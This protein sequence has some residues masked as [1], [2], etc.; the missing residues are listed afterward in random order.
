MPASMRKVLDQLFDFSQM[1][2]LLE[3]KLAMEQMMA[4]LLLLQLQ[5]QSEMSYQQISQAMAEESEKAIREDHISRAE[6]KTSDSKTKLE[7]GE[8]T[9]FNLVYYNPE[10]KKVE[11]VEESIT[12]KSDSYSSP[13]QQAVEEAAGQKSMQGPYS[14]IAQPTLHTRI[15]PYILDSVLSRIDVEAPK[16]FGGGA[17][18]VPAAVFASVERRMQAEG[19]EDEVVALK[20]LREM[21]V[22][23]EALLKSM[24]AEI[25]AL[26]D[27]V[28]ALQDGDRKEEK[29][30]GKLP[31]L[32]R[33]RYLAL[34]RR[35]KGLERTLLADLLIADVEFLEAVKNNLKGLSLRELAGV[36]RKFRGLLGKGE[37]KPKSGA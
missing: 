14:L 4:P 10:L 7:S 11:M 8:V 33:I 20:A 13:E 5:R 26:E 37:G 34:L 2:P 16:P 36:V 6:T 32:S 9:Q 1:S 21:Q 17:A 23:K 3:Q 27:A 12:I 22:R 30:L 18:H 31:P 25:I 29:I 15:D 28:K 35:R 19:Q 24:G